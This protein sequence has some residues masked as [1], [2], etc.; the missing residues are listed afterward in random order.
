MSAATIA[1]EIPMPE[2]LWD[3]IKLVIVLVEFL[4][5]MRKL[6]PIFNL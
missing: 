2:Y 5:I 6:V 4:E 1:R 3:I